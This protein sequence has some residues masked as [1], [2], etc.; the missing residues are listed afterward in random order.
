MSTRKDELAARMTGG[1]V[2]RTTTEPRDRGKAAI[3]TKPV[4]VTL[5]LDPQTYAAFNRWLGTA[6]VTLD[7]EFPRL[8][9]AGALRAMIHATI[10]DT[11]VA[12]TVL[13][14]LR[15]DRP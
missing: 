11:G 13:G 6:A 9:L 10:D 8:S 12:D 1:A 5:D 3:R 4:R 15:R 14:T 7:P 2:K